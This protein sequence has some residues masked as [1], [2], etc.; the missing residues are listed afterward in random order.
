MR[1]E[2]NGTITAPSE[3]KNWRCGSENCDSWLHFSHIDGIE[4]SGSGMISAGG[5]KWWDMKRGKDKPAALRVTNSRNVRLSGLRF[6]DNPKMHIVLNGGA[7]CIPFV[8]KD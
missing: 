1:V 5:Q 6:K 3:P 4:I 7:N 8:F 2:I